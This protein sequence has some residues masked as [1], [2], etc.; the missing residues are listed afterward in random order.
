MVRLAMLLSTAFGVMPQ[1]GG[2]ASINT[3][4]VQ[5]KIFNMPEVRPVDPFW[6]WPAR[7]ARARP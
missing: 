5:Q 6:Q 7:F 4:S 1:D 2:D 3:Q